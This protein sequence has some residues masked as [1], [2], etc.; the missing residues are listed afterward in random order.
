MEEYIKREDVLNL[1]N[2]L[3]RDD[4]TPHCVGYPEGWNEALEQ[5]ESNIQ[6]DIPAADVRSERHGEW[7]RHRDI[8]GTSY[9]CSK[10]GCG[11]S[12]TNTEHYCHYCGAKMDGENNG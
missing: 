2:G 1:I 3:K 11:Q 7:I 9:S 5:I 4:T 8:H 10:C 12:D 6:E